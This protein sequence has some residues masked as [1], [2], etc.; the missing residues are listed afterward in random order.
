MPGASVFYKDASGAVF[1][2]YSAYARGLDILV[3]AYNFLDL[4][5][6]GRDEAELP[7][8]MAWVRH[9]DKYEGAAKSESCCGSGG[10]KDNAA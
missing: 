1:H 10:R 2:T 7:W 6:K 5:P 3:G 9:H 4:T 8:T